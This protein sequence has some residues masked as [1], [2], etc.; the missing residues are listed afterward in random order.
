MNYLKKLRK[1]TG[2]FFCDGVVNKVQFYDL[3]VKNLTNN[4]CYDVIV[5]WA[6]LEHI[7]DPKKA[8][9]SMYSAL[10]SGGICSHDYHPFFC[11]SGAHFD[12]LDFPWGHVR[13]APKDFD[14]YIQ[15][16]RPQEYAIAMKRFYK[17]INRMTL[18][19]LRQFSLSAGFEILD[20]VLN[21]DIRLSADKTIFSQCKALYPSLTINDLLTHG[22]QI[23][24]RKP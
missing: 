2:S 1:A 13:L 17:S 9:K 3:D 6:V 21:K 15:T 23:L 11:T 5:S 16:Y 4:N 14:R 24:L 10:R 18:E 20:L 19:D 8:I 7:I 12:T 22:V